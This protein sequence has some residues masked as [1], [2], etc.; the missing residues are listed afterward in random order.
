MAGFI[1]LVFS[2][3]VIRAEEGVESSTTSAP[4]G[5]NIDPMRNTKTMDFR[6]AAGGPI[7][8]T[9]TVNHRD[10]HLLWSCDIQ[11]EAD[12]V[13]AA[14]QLNRAGKPSTPEIVLCP[15]WV[16][17]GMQSGNMPPSSFRP[18]NMPP[19][20]LF[21]PKNNMVIPLATTTDWQTISQPFSVPY[22]GDSKEH[23]ITIW[24]ML[25][26]CFVSAHIKNVVLESSSAQKDNERAILIDPSK[27]H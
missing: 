9:V 2:L 11:F 5:N 7:P 10:R 1:L 24:F 25:R 12:P 16:P 15:G 21:N 3:P 27:D 13:A 22:D 8:M 17:N 6:I 19:N 18:A 26:N 20:G 4:M 14:E 23:S